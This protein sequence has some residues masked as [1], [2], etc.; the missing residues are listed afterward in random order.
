MCPEVIDNATLMS[1]RKQQFMESRAPKLGDE[2]AEFSWKMRRIRILAI[3]PIAVM[4]VG[5]SVGGSAWPYFL[6]AMVVMWVP[7]VVLFC[8]YLWRM[9]QAASKALGITIDSKAEHSPPSKSPAYEEW[10]TKNGL[11]PYAAS[12]RFGRGKQ[13]SGSRPS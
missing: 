12:E 3:L 8:V 6:L 10:C 2:A 11:T 4:W 13:S 9:N 7:L 1:A 5:L